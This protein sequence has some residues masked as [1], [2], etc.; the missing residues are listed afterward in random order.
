MERVVTIATYLSK[1]LDTIKATVQAIVGIWA[2]GKVFGGVA[3]IGGG[4]GG[5]MKNFGGEFGKMAEEKGKV[6]GSLAAAGMIAQAGAIGWEVGRA[7]DGWLQQ[8]DW[9]KKSMTPARSDQEVQATLREQKAMALE[10][11]RV[12]AAR[13]ML[14]DRMQVLHVQGWSALQGMLASQSIIS[15]GKLAY[16]G[17]EFGA[18][19]INRAARQLG[20][21][22][23][24]GAP[25]AT[26]DLE[27]PKGGDNYFYNS[28]FDITQQF[29]PGFDPDRIAAAF[30]S[31]LALL[32]DQPREAHIGRGAPFQRK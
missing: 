24:P 31:D 12:D 32:A 6:F 9:W 11:A 25:V 3:G 2:A 21:L 26:K 18:A 5:L 23:A 15:G 4:A 16:G 8:Q 14:Q 13:T 19:Y 20:I 7:V 29:A 22:Q 1:H 28:R 10:K 17:Q 30:T 27:R